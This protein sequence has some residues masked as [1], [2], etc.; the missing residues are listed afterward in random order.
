MNENEEIKEKAPANG[1]SHDAPES[2]AGPQKSAPAEN[3]PQKNA[4]P[5]SPR[6]ADAAKADGGV[7]AESLQYKSG[8][9]VAKS[10]LLGFFI[11]LAVIVPGISGSTVAVI[12]RLYRKFIFVTSH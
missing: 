9:E 5:E 11:G 3:A 4:G 2:G 6:E 12:F 10:G 8:K 1:A 7:T